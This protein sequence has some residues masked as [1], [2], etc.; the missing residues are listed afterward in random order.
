MESLVNNDKFYPTSVLIKVNNTEDKKYEI[1]RPGN[2]SI[3]VPI[4]PQIE[5]PVE[6]EMVFDK[7]FMPKSLTGSS[8][9]RKLSCLLHKIKFIS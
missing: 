5:S 3:E 9:S 8:D 4:N 7:T 1:S 6:V 2:F